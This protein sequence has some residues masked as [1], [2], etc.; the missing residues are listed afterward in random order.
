MDLVGRQLGPYRLLALIGRGGTAEVYKAYHPA[1]EREVAVK[2]LLREA[3]QDED[4]VRRFRQEAHLLG[5]LDHPHILP[6]YDAGNYEGRPYLVMKYI[7]NGVTLK[8]QLTGAPW[9]VS[10]AIK[11]LSQV[12]EALQAAH[13]AGVVHRDVKPSN[14]LV[15]PELRC[16]V[17][18]FGI[19]KPVRRE[20]TST[21]GGLIV[22]TPEFMS[23][24]QCKGER[25]DHRSD[26]YA[27][28]VLAYQMLTGRLPF[29]SETAVGV[30]MKHL[31]EPIPI[32]PQSVSLSPAVNR[33][34]R[35]ALARSADERYQSA[36]DFSQA[37]EL[38]AD[39]SPTMTIKA[40]SLMLAEALTL[41][42][43]RTRLRASTWNRKKSVLLAGAT[44]GVAIGFAAGQLWWTPEAVAP[45]APEP[46]AVTAAGRTAVEPEPEQEE[47]PAMAD[48]RKPGTPIAVG[49]RQ[50]PKPRRTQPR[51]IPELEPGTLRIESNVPGIVW[52]D[53]QQI[54][55]A[56]AV[57]HPVP[58]GRHLVKLDA[59]QGRVDE[60]DV[61]ITAGS[62]WHLKFALPEHPE[63]TEEAP[64]DSELP[65]DNAG[66][67]KAA[68]A[69]EE[70]ND[71]IIRTASTGSGASHPPLRRWEGWLTDG[72]CRERGGIEGAAHLRC[73]E[74]CIRLG[75][76]PLLYSGRRLYYLKGYQRILIERG[77][78]LVFTGWLD[79][80]TNTI[81][82]AEEP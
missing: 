39:E 49:R 8:E 32:P 3:S 81:H 5:K 61:L 21:G 74:R 1:L 46:K 10:R 13:E 40:K 22:G 70:G 14:I 77:K 50:Q 51:A 33:V 18:D 79:Y 72:D 35:R 43:W 52:M 58:P 25:L 75:R 64:A 80:E 44:L 20:D 26:I 67:P 42:S 56:P 4:W 30:L 78:P 63:K 55:T 15:T 48:S 47:L 65:S 19:A 7:S 29:T 57:F 12:A 60:K 45:S 17:F 38:A 59:G 37:L 54:G 28:G 53:G 76:Q 24:E 6:I 31:T 71:A 23:P 11:V 9:P 68:R 69:P 2:V 66:P 62:T 27:M 82:V 41:R 73:A 34:L 36:R 16:L